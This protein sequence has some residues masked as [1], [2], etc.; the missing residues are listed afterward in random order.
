MASPRPTFRTIVLAAA[1]VTPLFGLKLWRT[2]SA[3]AEE[4]DPFRARIV[5]FV[6]TYCE[7]CHNA[8]HAEAQLNLQRYESAEMAAADFRQWEHVATFLER[9]EMPPAAAQLQ[10]TSAER[11]DVLRA[12]REALAGEA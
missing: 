10:P 6:R 12:L 11:E 9:Q 5:P 2:G 3:A 1:V 4:I 8:D 7:D